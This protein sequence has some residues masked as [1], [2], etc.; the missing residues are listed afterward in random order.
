MKRVVSLVGLVLQVILPGLAETK[1]PRSFAAP[2]AA[3]YCLAL[4]PDGKYLAV[5]GQDGV[6]RLWDVATKKEA[7]HLKAGQ[8]STWGVAFSPDSKRLAAAGADNSVR[9]WDV[10]TGKEIHLLRGHTSTVW[11][12]TFSPDGNTIASGS[13]DLTIRL[14]SLAT[15]K[16]VLRIG[17]SPSGV[18]PLAFAP[19]GK[20]LAAGYSNG[21]LILWDP[22]N[23]QRIRQLRKLASGVWPLVFS[24]DGRTLAAG[25]Y[26]TTDVF[27]YD[28]ATGNRRHL[29]LSQNLGWSLAFSP[30]GRTLMSG[31]GDA[32]VYCWEVATGKERARF[33]G[34]KAPVH[35][36]GLS[37]TGRL[38]ASTDQGGLNIVRDI[39]DLPE[40]IN[41]AAGDLKG[42]WNDLKDADAAK[43]YRS[44][45][46]LQAAP[47]FAVP[48][49]RERLQP[50][51]VV[52][53]DA[54][55]LARLIADLDSDKFIARRDATV[56][57]EKLGKLAEK[58]LRQ[59]LLDSPTPEKR[60][61]IAL[62]LSRLE[63]QQLTPDQVQ[64]L[65]ALEV[66]EILGTPAARKVFEELA[67]Q[68]NDSWL[69]QEAKASLVRL[70]RRVVMR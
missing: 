20:T 39:P 16:E 69:S 47:A 70:S 12:L 35:A 61:R 58:A 1:E 59:A 9:V 13:E 42:L 29:Q 21:A 66:L 15:G 27:L 64:T 68:E 23:G 48:F 7:R 52:L 19:D 63:G 4:S 26:N 40:K 37:S 32:V 54:K 5:P 50:R 44:I 51:P 65:R 31:G 11:F 8:V 28:A 34:H 33:L 10:G 38:A 41:L 25:L 57:L 30:D 60:M 36:V 46:T 24:P 6:L 43:A 18:W 53:P 67:K 49:L 17:G 55:T 2:T 22:A 3:G 14:W 45:W 62:L 56:A